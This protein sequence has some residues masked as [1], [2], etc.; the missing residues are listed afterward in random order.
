MRINNFIKNSI[1]LLIIIGISVFFYRNQEYINILRSVDPLGLMILL[2]T[3]TIFFY[4]AGLTFSLL[5]R[6]LKVT[7]TFSE[8]MG[9]SFMGNI[10]NYIAPFS[11]GFLAK[12]IFLKID[13]GLNLTNYSSAVASNAFLLLSV[14][15]F[16]GVAITLLNPQI[17]EFWYLVLA[18]SF[19][20]LL[21]TVLFFKG[22][23]LLIILPTSFIRDVVTQVSSG[24]IL[25]SKDKKILLKVILTLFLQIIF[26]S[27]LMFQ[28]FE[29]I[30]Q[31]I[32]FNAAFLIAIFTILSNFFSIT[33]GNI[34]IQ[35]IV[36]A[37][38]STI[39]GSDFG[40]GLLVGS[41]LRAAHIFITFTLGSL[42]LFF[43]LRGANLKLKRL[44]E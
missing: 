3:L 38:L 11:P 44:F 9:L 2:I 26:S 8:L 35:E 7:L 25:I 33:P 41:I 18:S 29:I 16:S 24:L 40:H 39:Y 19:I 20:F 37:F 32:G 17:Q 30:G 27:L 6:P 14:T 31:P 21:S 43:T 10:A 4:I 22:S 15:S 12:G 28:L 34:G 13:K 1:L 36:M 23:L 5:L 42:F